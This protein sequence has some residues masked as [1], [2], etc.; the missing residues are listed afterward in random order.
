MY[1]NLYF[2]NSASLE[3]RYKYILNLVFTYNLT[4]LKLY[5]NYVVD[6]EAIGPLKSNCRGAL[7]IIPIMA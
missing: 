1:K 6:T 5:V 2:L 7:I 4:N 3:N